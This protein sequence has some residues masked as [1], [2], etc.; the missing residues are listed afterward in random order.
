MF[1][2]GS[3]FVICPD[4]SMARI[5]VGNWLSGDVYRRAAYLTDGQNE[6]VLPDARDVSDEQLRQ[7]GIEKAVRELGVVLY[8]P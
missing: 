8:D 2:D 3:Q 6:T 1:I 4:G 5:V 7:L